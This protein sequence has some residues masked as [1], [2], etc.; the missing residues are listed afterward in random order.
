MNIIKERA[1]FRDEKKKYYI[2]DI[3]ES[4]HKCDILYGDVVFVHS[5]LSKFGKLA[6]IKNR[7]E[8]NLAFL[9]ACLMA[10]GNEGTLVVPTFTYSFCRGKMF[11]VENS[12]SELNYFTEVARTSKGFIRSDNPI[13]SVTSK[14]PHTQK[15]FNNLSTE[16]L[17]KD[18]IFER[19]HQLNAKILLLGFT[20]GSTFIHYVE[21]CLNVP[22]RYNKIFNGK[23]KKEN[24]IFNKSYNYF[25][26]DLKTDL[27]ISLDK[28]HKYALDHGY[29]HKIN[30]GNGEIMTIKTKDLFKITSEMLIKDPYAL[31]MG[32]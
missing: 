30:L 3:V 17:G 26:R 12:Q 27:H 13:F 9:N 6:D 1:V 7:K 24:K 11:D 19:L 10:I 2:S 32:S 15:L 21:S 16:C 8:W 4:L 28:I 25:V 14:G 20:E 22:Y 5:D 18:S 31:I 29:L 23:I